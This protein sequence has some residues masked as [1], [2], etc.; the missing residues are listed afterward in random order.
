MNVERRIIKNP[1]ITNPTE[2]FGEVEKFSN[3]KLKQ[4][5]DLVRLIEISF[6]NNKIDLLEKAAFTAKYLQ[7][8]FNIIQRGDSAVNK[9]IFEKYSKEYSENVEQLKN[10]LK[11][12]LK[13]GSEFYKKIFEEKYFA[14][15]HTSISSLNDLC[16]DLSWVKM[17]LNTK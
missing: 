7:G 2:F 4:K 6:K 15:T 16:Y 17:Y 10:N 5:E 14:L 3:S 12:L 8:L 11:E 1:E 13:D 9:E